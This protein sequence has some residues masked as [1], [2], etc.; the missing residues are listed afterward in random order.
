M[1]LIYQIV[2]HEEQRDFIRMFPHWYK[3]LNRDPERY[4]E[5][6]NELNELKKQSQP[7]RLEKIEKQINFAQIMLKLFQNK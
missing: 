7:T 2:N 6:V 1:D 4:L 5:F 3:E